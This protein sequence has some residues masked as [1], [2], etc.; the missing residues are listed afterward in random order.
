M[1]K[2]IKNNDFIW[3]TLGNLFVSF[4]SML[5]MII[6]VR[7]N[8]VDYGGIFNYGFTIA[9][10]FYAI[11]QYGGRTLHVSDNNKVL[12][13]NDFIA[14]RVFTTILSF[15][16]FI[17]YIAICS[18]KLDKSIIMVLLCVYKLI[19]ALSDVLHGGYQKNDKLHIAGK[20]MVLRSLCA[21]IIFCLSEILFKSLIISCVLLIINNL[22][23]LGIDIYISKKIIKWEYYFDFEKVK[24]YLKV[25][26][27]T[28]A[29]TFLLLF[30]FNIPRYFIDAILNDELQAIY[31]IIIMP[32]SLI[33][34]MGHLIMQ[35]AVLNITKLHREKKY[36][37]INKI[38]FKII[39]LSI[40]LCII[41]ILGTILIGIPVLEFIYKINLKNQLLNLIFVIIGSLFYLISIFLSTILIIMRK[42]GFQLFIYIFSSIIGLIISYFMISSYKLNG[43]VICYLI[44]MFIQMIMY[45]VYYIYQIKKVGKENEQHT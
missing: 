33:S 14:A 2:R 18:Y 24:Y 8:G 20:S 38:L 30:S 32:A 1:I 12:N 39:L 16:I 6:V 10:I 29:F 43:G 36:K 40:I 25:A 35:P 21:S 4:L 15:L 17:F 19:E 44:L 28:F 11:A 45:I 7:I 5:F 13:E 27:F 41:L 37:E 26:F 22:I 9:F 34:L 31:G 3:N 42:T 23:F